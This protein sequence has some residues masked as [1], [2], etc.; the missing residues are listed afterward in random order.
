M[1]M[2]EIVTLLLILSSVVCQEELCK[3][4]QFTNARNYGILNNRFEITIDN[5]DSSRLYYRPYQT[6][7]G[8]YI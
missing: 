8:K 6:I 7:K 2:R 1:K 3:T 5:V 4:S